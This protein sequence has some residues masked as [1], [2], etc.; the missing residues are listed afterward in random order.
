MFVAGAGAYG[1]TDPDS[2]KAACDAVL[3]YINTYSYNPARPTPWNQYI[4]KK[5]IERYSKLPT[6]AGGIVFYSMIVIKKALE[7]AG[8]MFSDDPLNPNHLRQAFLALDLED[9]FGIVAQ[10]YPTGRIKFNENGDDIYAGTAVLQV[11]GI[12]GELKPVVVWPDAEPGIRPIFPRP[13]W[14]GAK[15]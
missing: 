9:R 15:G 1:Y 3:W 2:I 10:P 13:D 5:L 4:V 8:E 11:Q 12:S 14:P 7:K 6:E